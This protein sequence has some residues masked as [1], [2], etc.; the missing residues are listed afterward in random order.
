MIIRTEQFEVGAE[1]DLSNGHF[2]SV[3]LPNGK[4]LHIIPEDIND[5]S[6]I[7]VQVFRDEKHYQSEEPPEQFAL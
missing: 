4:I 1:Y 2:L 5:T 6:K 3:R 7:C